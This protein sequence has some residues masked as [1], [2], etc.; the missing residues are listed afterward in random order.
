MP[1]ATRG[2]DGAKKVPG[3]KRHIVVDCLG[4]LLAVMVTAANVTDQD[5]AMTLLERVRAR[6]HRVVLVWADR[7]Y[8]GRLVSRAKQQ[9]GLALEI[10]KRSD[11]AS[12]FVVLPRRRLVERTLSWLMRSRRLVR[13]Y[14]T[15]PR[16]A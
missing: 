7:G 5:T 1:A 14:E 10:A 15:L 4:L 8:S 13:D 2:Y 9:L 12:G 3:R 6:Y 11:D 16:R